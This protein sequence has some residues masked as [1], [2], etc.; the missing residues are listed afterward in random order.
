MNRLSDLEI[1]VQV[2][3]TGSYTKAATA[4]GISKSYA[5]KQVRALE[6]RL[7]VR[8]LHRTTRTVTPTDAGRR[9]V[10]RCA[11][12]LDELEAAERDAA[13]QQDVPRGRLRVSAPVSFGTRYVAPALATFMARHPALEVVADLSDRRVDLVEE[14][15]DLAVRIG[16]L[17]DSSHLA[18][19]LAPVRACLVASPAYV[20]A[21]G[22]PS[23]PEALR[24]HACLVYSLQASPTSWTLTPRDGGGEPVR[25][26]VNARLT[27]NNGDALL[28]AA[29]AGVGVA[30]LPDFFVGDAIRSGAL[31]WLL[32]AWQGMP[33]SGVWAVH[34]AGR[35]VP[36]KVR[37][38]VEHL[39]AALDPAPWSLP[40]PP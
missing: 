9:L 2:V 14:G 32:P 16:R 7:G 8:L 21:H 19:R 26:R 28:D 37:L 33:P 39:A 29:L 23:E 10:D 35:F 12:L 18:R 1:L 13:A 38:L 15:Y 40:A 31:R 3:R 20:A 6:E 36:A 30:S 22:A 24:E 4:L 27:S 34:P 25:V 5:S 11:G 17:E